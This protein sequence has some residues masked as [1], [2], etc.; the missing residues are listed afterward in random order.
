M[1]GYFVEKKSVNRLLLA[2]FDNLI[3]VLVVLTL[4]IFSLLSDKFF[5]PFNLVNIIPR[6]A[7]IGLLIIGQSFTM[8]T[9]NFDLSSESN[10]GFTAMIAGLLLVSTENGGLGVFLSTG[11]VIPIMLLAGMLVGVIN[12]LL[13]TKLKVNN[14][15]V[16]I[17]MLI[18][19]R[20]VVYIINPGVTATKF[21]QAYDWLGS[22][23]L[24]KLPV[25]GRYVDVPVSMLFVIIAFAVAFIITRYRQ[26]GRDMY[27][28]GANREAAEAV[29]IQSDKVILI[30][31]IISGLFA[32]LAG[33][34]TSGRMD[35]ATP[36]TGADW[37]FQV[38]AAAIIGG[39]SLFGGR[40]NMIGAMGGML[41]WGII[42]TG[43]N[44][45]MVDPLILDLL[46]GLL[47]LFAMLLDAFKVRYLHRLAVNEALAD[48][49]IGL[50]HKKLIYE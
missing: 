33:L 5:T 30:V 28:V 1:K 25:D 35:A 19:L 31:Y 49:K 20:G 46:R 9:G 12:G 8:I 44:M 39:I 36:R 34:Q 27:A 37:I 38:Q 40:G 7:P 47:L 17:S 43:L 18:I 32:A 45:M 29:G 50:R 16:T 2:L 24:F 21:P 3:W 23:T 14:L 41:L 6:V 22:G 15:I 11:V 4:I 48:T 42:D 13:V 10:V 26:F